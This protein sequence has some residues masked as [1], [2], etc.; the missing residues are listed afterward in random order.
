MTTLVTTDAEGRFS[1]FRR[2]FQPVL[3]IQAVLPVPA[4][5]I[6]DCPTTDVQLRLG[7]GARFDPTCRSFPER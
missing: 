4:G 7:P 5:G 2:S 1:V 6:L 3:G